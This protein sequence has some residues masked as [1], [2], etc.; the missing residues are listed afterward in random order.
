MTA[1]VAAPGPVLE[2]P[3]AEGASPGGRVGAGGGW[4]VARRCAGV[5]RGGGDWTARPRA[6]RPPP[7]ARRGPGAGGRRG[8]GGGGG[9]GGAAGAAARAALAGGGGGGGGSEDD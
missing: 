5:G 1:I 7:G 6:P 3:P 9:G 4:E 2:R 8:G